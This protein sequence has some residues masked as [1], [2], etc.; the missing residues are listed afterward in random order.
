MASLERIVVVGGSLAGLRAAEA[1]RQKGF[2]GTLSLVGAENREPYD[3]PPLSKDVLAG[4]WEPG[5][6]ALARDGLAPLE[7][8]LHLGCRAT[9]LDPAAREIELEDGRRLGFDG[10]VIATGAT[11]RTL[12]FEGPRA[13]IHTLRTLDDCIALRE[14][15]EAGPRVTVVG[16]GFIGAEVAA[17][18]RGRG[19]EVTV[20]EATAVPLERAIGAQMGMV[21]ASL[22]RDHGVDL[23]L[24]AGVEGFEGS[25][26]VEG[27]RLA[28]GETV[29]A[30]VVVVGVG[31]TPNS[32]WLEGSG[33]EL[34]NGIVCDATCA[35]SLPAV[36]AAGDV[37]SWHNPQ[38]DEQ[39]RV[40]HWTNAVEQGRAAALNLL[41]GA[42]HATPFSSVPYFWSDQYETK[43]QFVGHARPDD[44]VRVAH[45]AVGDGQF[46][47][48]Y[49]RGGR[50]VAALGFDRAR[51]L[52]GY[53]A[54]IA[55][56]TS[57]Q[58]AL[59][60]AAGAQ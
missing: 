32:A 35:R 57:W 58:A 45:G 53:R 29:A 17:V 9:G 59:D 48:L 49:G 25:T 10:L 7:L 23:R 4:R 15:F 18:A 36:Y 12:P 5:Q 27:V 14:A 41:A 21:C 40:E 1:L 26:R 34:A 22:H 60:R 46:V 20:L 56:G 52:I 39:M 6:T 51:L 30:D 33:I 37:A 16:E 47:A 24:G 54:M 13:G 11:P 50:L 43:I 8:D 28:G 19:L 44:R 2:E 42:E 55:D 3:R 38:F 31:V